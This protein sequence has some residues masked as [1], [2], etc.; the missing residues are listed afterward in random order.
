[1]SE[2]IGKLSREARLLFIG[3]WSACDDYGRTRAASRFLASQLFPYDED[4]PSLIESWL[5]EL[6]D[7]GMVRLYEHDGCR[8][9]DIP[10]W[11]DHQKIDRPSPSKLP[12]FIESSR[13]LANHRESSSL[14]QGT[15]NREQ[16][17]MEQG[18]DQSASAPSNEPRPSTRFKPPTREELNLEAAKIG[19][20][21]SEVDKFVNHYAA[22]GWKVGR[23]PMKSW[24]HALA[25][26]KARWQERSHQT[27]AGFQRPPNGLEERRSLLEM[28]MKHGNPPNPD[29]EAKF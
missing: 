3:L 7:F 1:M 17:P 20:P 2:S 28:S 15:G 9:L 25:G 26:W 23:N 24:P 8:Y 10:K 12:E 18:E 13:I 29:R 14:E 6:S 16:G 21:D 5:R 22:V 4:A 27:G 11:F 19:L